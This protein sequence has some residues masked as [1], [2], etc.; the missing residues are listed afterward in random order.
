MAPLFFSAYDKQKRLFF[1]KKEVSYLNT[2][3]EK[4]I[5]LMK[6]TLLYCS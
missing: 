1:L 4:Y 5:F 6:W 3:N 2:F